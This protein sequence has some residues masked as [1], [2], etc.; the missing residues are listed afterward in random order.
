MRGL[1]VL[2]RDAG[3]DLVLFL[4]GLGCVKECFEGAWG[5]DALSGLSLLAPDL[6]GSGVSPAP[7]GFGGAMEEHATAVLD[8]L[9]G[10]DFARLHVVAHSMGGAVGLLLS[11]HLSPASFMCVEGN[12]IAADRSLLSR[13]AAATPYDSFVAEKFASLCR[14]SAKS[15][16]PGIK[17]WAR[18]GRR[19]TPVC[20]TGPAFPWSTGPTAGACWTC[21]RA[22]TGKRPISTAS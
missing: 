16:D 19:R 14:A 3:P 7:A 21:F 20:S 18:W 17:T 22:W 9:G 10:M 12:L 2:R 4:H 11:R 5:E 8:L 1:S 15:A 6:P 13:R